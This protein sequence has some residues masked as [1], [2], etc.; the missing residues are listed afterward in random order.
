M[1]S[2]PWASTPGLPVNRP[3]R[4]FPVG[5]SERQNRPLTAFAPDLEDSATD[6]EATVPVWRQ[7]FGRVDTKAGRE[8][9][10]RRSRSQPCHERHCAL[11][12]NCVAVSVSVKNAWKQIS[13][14]ST[15][16]HRAL[17]MQ[18]KHR[19]PRHSREFDGLRASNLP[20]TQTA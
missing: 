18:G 10:R 9:I 1:A 5:D 3:E 17:T 15:L 12:F 13:L 14:M 19:L 8:N 6:I 7:L 4:S 20:R 11:A 2:D 16:F